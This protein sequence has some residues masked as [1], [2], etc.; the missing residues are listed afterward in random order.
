MAACLFFVGLSTYLRKNMGL[1]PGSAAA[2]V[3]DVI[4]LVALA[5]V[6]IAFPLGVQVRKMK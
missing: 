6:G 5:G 1:E 4:P 2:H 3:L